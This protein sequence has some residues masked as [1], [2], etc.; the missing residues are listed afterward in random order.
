M[1]FI[2]QYKGTDLEKITKS[3][4][5]EDEYLVGTKYDGN[6]IQIHKFGNIV[7]FFT[8]GGKEFRLLDIGAELVRLNPNTDFIIETEFIGNTN[9]K[10]G[11]RGRCSTG[12]WRANFTKSIPSNAFS[13]KFKCFDILY[14][15]KNLTEIYSREP[16]D[17]FDIRY[18]DYLPQLDLG[19]NVDLVDF[20]Y[21]TLEDAKRLSQDLCSKGWE[22]VFAFHPTHI[23]KD[24]GRS[25]LAIKIKEKPTADL[26]CYDVK[27]SDINPKD[28]GSLLLRDIEG[29]EVA[30]GGLEHHLKAKDPSYFIG[31]FIE[32][33]YES[34]GVNTYVQPS[35]KRIREDKDDW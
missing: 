8:S 3:N 11:S 18:K 27:Y 10:L 29:R 13:T 7:R 5:K 26:L 4:H 1:D 35:F 9:G 2:K 12:T 34:M 19:T 20:Q 16:E 22:G 6:Y 30:A 24:K 31:K 17:N 21:I 25:Q 33:N 14:L 23:H 32:I 15:S 28:I